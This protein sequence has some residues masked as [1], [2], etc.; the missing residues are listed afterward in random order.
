MLPAVA[1][2][3]GPSCSCRPPAVAAILVFAGWQLRVSSL[4]PCASD[5]TWMQPSAW[6]HPAQSAC[7]SLT[8]LHIWT[9]FHARSHA[10]V[11]GRWGL[12]GR[13]CSPSAQGLGRGNGQPRPQGRQEPGDHPRCHP[14][15]QPVPRPCDLIGDTRTGSRAGEPGGQLSRRGSS[16]AQR[17]L[18]CRS[19][20]AVPA[21]LLSLPFASG[22]SSWQEVNK[23][24]WSLLAHLEA[25]G[26]WR[27]GRS[28]RTR[29][30]P[31]GEGGRWAAPSPPPRRN[32]RPEL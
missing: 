25:G 22:L 28:G 10:E 31:R 32:H 26:R 24:L 21:D 18:H 11:L 13:H 14:A 3:E 20:A 29:A 1:P 16:W 8:A 2:G 9:S 23:P 5:P 19:H 4:Y 12:G 6:A 7:S 27:L 30:R 17:G 15:F